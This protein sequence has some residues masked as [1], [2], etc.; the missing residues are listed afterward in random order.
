LAFRHAGRDARVIRFTPESTKVSARVI[1][2]VR[3]LQRV[4]Q[5]SASLSGQGQRDQV[6]SFRVE[7]A[8]ENGDIKRYLQ[9]EMRGEIIHGDLADGDRVEV[10]LRRAVNGVIRTGQIKNLSTNSSVWISNRFGIKLVQWLIALTMIGS[11]GIAAYF[12]L[13]T[14]PGSLFR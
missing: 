11:F 7:D 1:G 9:I 12:A 14:D 10:N 4:D 3:N 13:T 8:D 6:L 5:S 2:T